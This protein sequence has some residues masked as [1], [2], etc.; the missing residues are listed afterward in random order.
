MNKI[1]TSI[2]H[3][4]EQ[5]KYARDRIIVAQAKVESLE[6][7]LERLQ[8]IEQNESIPHVEVLKPKYKFVHIEANGTTQKK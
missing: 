1:Q 8:I 3:I 7:I 2:E 4:K 5:I 6:D